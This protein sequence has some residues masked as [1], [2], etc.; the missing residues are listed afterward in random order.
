MKNFFNKVGKY[1]LNLLI[2]CLVLLIS[3][4]II[5]GDERTE[6]T[7]GKIGDTIQK[8]INFR[9]TETIKVVEKTEYKT[10]TIDLMQNYSLQEVWVLKNQQRIANFSEG[11]ATIRVQEGDLIS[12]DASAYQGVLWFEITSISREIRNWSKGEQIR[13][14]GTLIELGIVKMY[15]EI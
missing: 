2:I 10:I 3:F 7:F 15:G 1:F 5:A 11:I 12:I 4:Q 8:Y 13:T 6:I 9:D 14:E